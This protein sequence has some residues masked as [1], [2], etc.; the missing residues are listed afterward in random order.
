M[1][2]FTR[3]HI[4]RFSSTDN[5]NKIQS[6]LL[7]R[8]TLNAEQHR[9]AA[10]LKL[11]QH[12]A[13]IASSI[14]QLR[15]ILGSTA[16]IKRLHIELDS[17][18]KNAIVNP[19]F[20]FTRFKDKIINSFALVK[21][22]LKDEIGIKF[23]SG[24]YLV[25]NSLILLVAASGVVLSAALTTGPIGMVFLGL[26]LSIL[27]AFLLAAAAYSLYVDVRHLCDAQLEEIQDGI[28]FL[29]EYPALLEPNNEESLM[30]VVPS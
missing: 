22:E 29:N 19:R 21:D 16:S 13:N 9:Y 8:A 15:G 11:K 18:I 10:L 5:E 6:K 23:E 24:C 25:S 12:A 30:R 4:P 2:F 20:N 26:T 14:H 1:L 17:A 3:I 28:N 7:D 27:S